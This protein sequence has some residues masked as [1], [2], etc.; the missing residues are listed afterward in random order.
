MGKPPA[1]SIVRISAGVKHRCFDTRQPGRAG[2]FDRFDRDLLP[3]GRFASGLFFVEL[4]HGALRDEREDAKNAQLGCFLND[5]FDD[6]AFGNSDEE[7]DPAS[8]CQRLALLQDGKLD[9]IAIGRR[10]FAEAFLSRTVQNG[11]FV[12]PFK[13]QDANSVMRLGAG[14]EERR[15]FALLRRQIEAMH[16]IKVVAAEVTRLTLRAVIFQER[17]EPRYLGCYWNRFLA[18]SKKLWLRG[19]SF[20]LQSSAN[21]WSLVFWAG[22]RCVG[23]STFIRT[24]KSPCP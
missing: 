10:D 19:L 7:R 12:F 11:H 5:A 17:L 18:L 2:L 22:V 20:P 6:F 13:T 16:S 21:S 4:D 24:C 14:E 8:R 3:L 1:D 15:T 9:L 23:T